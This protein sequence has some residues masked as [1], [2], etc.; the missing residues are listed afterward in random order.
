[1]IY[2][3]FASEKSEISTKNGNR[4]GEREEHKG[5]TQKLRPL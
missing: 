1:M 5:G 3:F 2:A 4:E